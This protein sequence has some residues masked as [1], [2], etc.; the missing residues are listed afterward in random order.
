MLHG[1]DVAGPFDEVGV[2]CGVMDRSFEVMVNRF[3][4]NLGVMVERLAELD[5][6][7]HDAQCAELSLTWKASAVAAAGGSAA[8]AGGRVQTV[9]LFSQV[10]VRVTT[11]TN[12]PTMQLNAELLPDPDTATATT[13]TVAAGTTMDQW[14]S[15]GGGGSK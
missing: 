6:H 2:V 9:T 5:F 8:G 14:G 13:T 15:G 12:G 4:I 3:G 10:R 1:S 7:S 11:L